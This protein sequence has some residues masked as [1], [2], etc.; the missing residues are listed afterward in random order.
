MDATVA[1]LTGTLASVRA[2][3]D[4]DG[5]RPGDG[6]DGLLAFEELGGTG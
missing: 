3:A 5:L 2:K 6:E 4:P 1:L